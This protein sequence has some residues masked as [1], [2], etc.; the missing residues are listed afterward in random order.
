M[1]D[2]LTT[3][4]QLLLI[5]GIGGGAA[6]ILIELF[7]GV[8]LELTGI[9]TMSQATAKLVIGWTLL[10]A[11]VAAIAGLIALAASLFFE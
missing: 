2:K 10:A 7:G 5:F 3:F 6:A 9:Y 8:A 1:S 11:V 4:G